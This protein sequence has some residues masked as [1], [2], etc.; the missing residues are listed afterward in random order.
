M[1][2]TYTSSDEFFKD[3]NNEHQRCPKCGSKNH[4]VTLVFYVPNLQNP[5]DFKDVNRVRCV[6]CGF[7]GIVHDLIK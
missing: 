7:A 4:F 2:D 1:K 5:K 6:D 3:Y